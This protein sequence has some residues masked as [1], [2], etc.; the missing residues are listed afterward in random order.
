MLGVDSAPPWTS[1]SESVSLES[2]VFACIVNFGLRDKISRRGPR[3]LIDSL[4]PRLLHA[5]DISCSSDHFQADE[6][7]NRAVFE[8]FGYTR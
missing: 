8:A 4:T 7:K 6:M 1:E 5:L 2:S 3:H